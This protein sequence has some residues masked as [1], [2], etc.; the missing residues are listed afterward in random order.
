M[1]VSKINKR[2]VRKL[3]SE[4]YTDQILSIEKARDGETNQVYIIHTAPERSD[5]VIRISED[6]TKINDYIKEQWCMS[7]ARESGVPVPQVLEVSNSIVPYPYSVLKFKKGTPGNKNTKNREELWR[8]MG[9]L[10]AKIHSIKTK[11]YGSTFDWSHNRL[12]KYKS[13]EDYLVMHFKI[14]EVVRFLSDTR[15]LSTKATKRI[16][17][18]TRDFRTWRFKPVLCHNDFLTKNVLLSANGNITTVLDWE[19]AVSSHKYRDIGK[20]V[21][22]LMW[23][24]EHDLLPVFLKGY[25][26]GPKE[27]GTYKHYMFIF[28][29]YAEVYTEFLP[30]FPKAIPPVRLEEFVTFWNE[31]FAE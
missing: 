25:G 12:S 1:A 8:Q 19:L 26:I 6:Q 30:G 4:V 17:Q 5:L 16:K 3:V 28:D 29:L 13:W 10:L 14:D 23:L 22:H 24:G 31:I 21:R 20:T 15:I 27:Y 18:V 7:R 11:G 9:E 2:V